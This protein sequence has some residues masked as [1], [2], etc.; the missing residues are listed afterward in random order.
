MT[1]YNHQTVYTFCRKK[2]PD[3]LFKI[4]EKKEGVDVSSVCNKICKDVIKATRIVLQGTGTDF[5]IFPCQM[6]GFSPKE[7]VN[8]MSKRGYKLSIEEDGSIWCIADSKI[9]R[10]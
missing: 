2:E 5:K 10:N 4:K 3:F 6:K 7:I 9:I 8:E 1:T